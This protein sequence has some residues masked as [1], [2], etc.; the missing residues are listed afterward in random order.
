MIK[1][2]WSIVRRVDRGLLTESDGDGPVVENAAFDTAEAAGE[3]PTSICSH[4]SI[5]TQVIDI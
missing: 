4:K 5:I 1:R 3:R 2:Q